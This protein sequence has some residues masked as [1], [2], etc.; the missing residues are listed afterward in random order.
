MTN[1]ITINLIY[2]NGCKNFG[3]QLSPFIC[4]SL[5][6]KD[7]YNLV[8]NINNVDINI[9]CIGSFIHAAKNNTFIFG[10]GVRTDPSIEGGHNYKNLE[11]CAIRGPLSKKFIQNK[12]II[13]SDIFGDPA[14]LLPK[15]YKP[16]I[17]EKLKDKIGIIPHKS[18]YDKY[19]QMKLDNKY[20]LISP[21]DNWKIVINSLAS[22]KCIISSSL[23][24]LICS[25]AYNKP[26]VWLN[27]YKLAEGDFKFKDYFMSQNREYIVIK[28]INEYNHKFLYRDGNKI[29][30]DKLINAFPFR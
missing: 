15:F 18:N 1:K 30:L 19:K 25:D 24:G 7:K 20:Y 13:C 16:I 28:N 14:L 8:Y 17:N 12:N 27:E 6:D 21:T 10:S 9:I 5:I 26:N 22:C 2:F 3:D 23:H 11:V 29:D 4:R